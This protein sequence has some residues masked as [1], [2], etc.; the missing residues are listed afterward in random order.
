MLDLLAVE[1]Q[2]ANQ[3][4][5]QL[6]QERV[7]KNHEARRIAVAEVLAHLEYLRF[8]GKVKQL[9]TKEETILYAIV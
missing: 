3:S 2:N 9:R 4:T 8:Q 1:A 5:N 7:L 6:F